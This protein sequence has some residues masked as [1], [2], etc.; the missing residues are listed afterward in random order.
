MVVDGSYN[1]PATTS[2]ATRR[3]VSRNLELNELAFRRKA[4]AMML[5]TCAGKPQAKVAFQKERLRKKERGFQDK[6]QIL[7]QL[8]QTSG[9]S[10]RLI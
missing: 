3:A 5:D 4:T 7:Y 2:N 8:A 6:R 10:R 9:R 1:L